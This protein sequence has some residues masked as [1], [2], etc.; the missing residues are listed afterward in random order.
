MSWHGNPEITTI[1]LL[2]HGACEGGDVY[3]GSTDLALDETGWQQMRDAVALFDPLPWQ[4]VITSPLQRCRSFSEELASG[5]GLP[6]RVEAG[7]QELHFGDWEGRSFAEVWE[8]QQN[9]V[10]LFFA[11]PLQNAP[12]NGEPMPVFRERV[13]ESWN[14][15]IEDCRGQHGLLVAHGGTLRILLSEVLEM[16]LH[17]MVSLNVPYACLSRVIIYHTDERDAAQLVFH[18]KGAA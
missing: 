1:D 4:V 10:Q 17:K 5:A 8:E 16:P 6:L 15:V 11:N 7:L 18:N 9:H 14:S 12:P 3:R 2:R 13:L